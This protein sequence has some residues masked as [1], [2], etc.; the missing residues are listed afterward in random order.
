M[1]NNITKCK[2]HLLKIILFKK[3]KKNQFEFQT[4]VYKIKKN[5]QFLKD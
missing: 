3:K 2:I 5:L 4:S 1:L